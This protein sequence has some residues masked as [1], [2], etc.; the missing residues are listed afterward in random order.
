MNPRDSDHRDRNA[1][2]TITFAQ[3]L[4]ISPEEGAS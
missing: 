2:M 1:R 4:I 3:T